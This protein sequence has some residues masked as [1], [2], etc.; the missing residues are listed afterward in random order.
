MVWLNLVPFLNLVWIFLTVIRIS[1]SL[2]NEFRSRRLRSDDPEFGK[3]MGILAAVLTICC[4]PIGWIMAI[5]YWVKINGYK[6]TLASGRK[7]KGGDTEADDYDDDER[8]RRRRNADDDDKD[9][10]DDRPR[11]PRRRDDE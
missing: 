8:P 2:Q 7:G 1:E 9:D 5:I 6:N 10:E 11:K 4:G 3:M